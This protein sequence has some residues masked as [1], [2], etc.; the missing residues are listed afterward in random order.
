MFTDFSS[1]LRSYAQDSKRRLELISAKAEELGGSPYLAPVNFHP[2]YWV[3]ELMRR[4]DN[5]A[6]YEGWEALPGY[7]PFAKWSEADKEAYYQ[8]A[9]RNR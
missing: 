8:Y 1:S 7:I 3:E 2:A 9:L 6:E 5:M 4:Y